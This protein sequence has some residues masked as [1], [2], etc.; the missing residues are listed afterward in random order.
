MFADEVRAL[1]RTD[2]LRLVQRLTEEFA[3]GYAAAHVIRIAYR[4]REGLLAEG[5][6][7]GIVSATEVVVRMQLTDPSSVID[8]LH[9][10]VAG[11]PLAL[12]LL[13]T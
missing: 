10:N 2:M 3:E 12:R 5:L 8:L 6:R 4:A 1:S 7:T 11:Q 13:P 9:G